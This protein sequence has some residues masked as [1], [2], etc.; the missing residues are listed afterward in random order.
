MVLA[1]DLV[2]DLAEGGIVV[3]L[4]GVVV[5]VAG[6]DFYDSFP[7]RP[8]QDCCY[9]PV[10]GSVWTPPWLESRVA[11]QCSRVSGQGSRVAFSLTWSMEQM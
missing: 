6:V 3:V 10:L 11:G 7:Q 2:S 5:D 8:A 1:V 9:C 4:A